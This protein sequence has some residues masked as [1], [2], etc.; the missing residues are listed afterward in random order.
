M[1]GEPGLFG[2]KVAEN[3]STAYQIIIT[4]LENLFMIIDHFISSGYQL[5]CKTLLDLK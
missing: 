5:L 2:V 1:I 3:M 4:T